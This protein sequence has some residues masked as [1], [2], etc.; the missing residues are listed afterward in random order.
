MAANSH[1]QDPTNAEFFRTYMSQIF[2]G[3]RLV[4]RLKTDREPLDQELHG[5]RR[6]MEDLQ[7]EK[8]T[9]IKERDEI[10]H[11]IEAIIKTLEDLA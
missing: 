9:L 3:Y 2:P 1:K 4:E 8:A 5:M 6:R 7:G 10:R 11:Q